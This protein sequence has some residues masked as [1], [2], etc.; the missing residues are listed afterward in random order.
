MIS[1]RKSTQ[2]NTHTHGE[3]SAEKSLINLLVSHTLEFTTKVYTLTTTY[4][5]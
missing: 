2:Q 4:Y 5:T 1:E 3:R